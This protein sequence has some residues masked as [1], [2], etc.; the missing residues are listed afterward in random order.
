MLPVLHFNNLSNTSSIIDFVSVLKKRST[1]LQ[2]INLEMVMCCTG[3]SAVVDKA[4]VLALSHVVPDD[5]LN[6]AET[7]PLKPIYDLL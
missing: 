3:H 4:T 1:W 7:R 5:L 6:P 2:N